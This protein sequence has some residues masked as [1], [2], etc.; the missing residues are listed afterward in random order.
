MG[1]TDFV[2]E[3]RWVGE[4][5]LL[6]LQRLPQ[7]EPVEIVAFSV[8]LLFT[9][10]SGARGLLC[11]SRHREARP[12]CWPEGWRSGVVSPRQRRGS[13]CLLGEMRL[14]PWSRD[15]P[16]GMGWVVLG[17]EA[18][19]ILPQGWRDQSSGRRRRHHREEEV[20]GYFCPACPAAG[21][22]PPHLQRDFLGRGGAFLL[23]SPR[24]SVPSAS[25]R[26]S[27]HRAAAAAGRL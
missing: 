16:Q 11:S 27:R 26:P 17:P 25:P 5:L 10:Q 23:F 15:M 21:R 7:A 9:G 4:R 18:P 1:A 24:S 14:F 12:R 3:M 6:K 2:Q 8:I 20:L 22:G 13:S 19:S